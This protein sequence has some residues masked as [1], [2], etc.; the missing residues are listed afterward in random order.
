VLGQ[1]LELELPPGCGDAGSWLGS[2]SWD[3]INL[4]PRPE[5]RLWLGAT[6]EPGATANAAAREGLRQLNGAAPDW[7]RRARVI[8]HWMGSRARPVGRP[9]PLLERLEEGL[10]L[11]SGHY[12]NGVLLAPASAAWVADQIAS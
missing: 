9:A 1:A 5:G 3:G 12:R 10:L 4:V 6:L 11:A 2:V 8:R 7:L